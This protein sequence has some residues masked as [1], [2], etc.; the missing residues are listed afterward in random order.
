MM[1]ALL[2]RGHLVKRLPKVRGRYMPNA[3]L[4][5]YTWFKVGGPAEVIF[6]PADTEDLVHFLA[7]KPEDVPVTVIGVGSNLL[8]RDGGVPGVVIRLG[9]GFSSVE[10]NGTEVRAGGGALDTNV[11]K[12]CAE[13]GVA[14]LEFLSGIPGTIGGALRMNAGAYGTEMK[15]VTINA[16]A[17][18]GDGN[19]HG[20]SPEKLNFSYRK[21]GV[22]EDWL[23]TQVV[24]RGI[25]GD[26][27]KINERMAEIKAAREDSQPV[28]TSTGGS[29]FA[30][31]PEVSAWELID[32]AGCR[33]LS[34]GD[35]QVSHKHCN[36][37]VNKGEATAADLE[38]LGEE[39]RRRVFQTYGV[40]L[41]WEIRR[42][43][44]N[45]GP[46]AE[47]VKY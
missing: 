40:A 47:E 41:K 12:H 19:I 13:A 14:G 39:V 5:K 32:G 43:G 16:M 9:R 10:I 46:S 33:G 34:R 6:R 30:N 38:G 26:P 20:L 42:I 21:S 37:L 28:R 7:N 8:V 4:A 22:P 11:A 3:Q 23:F 31:P 25:E 17:V 24:M 45:D 29:T 36:F 27:T 44:V 15:D 18:D 35:A 1:A 2:Y